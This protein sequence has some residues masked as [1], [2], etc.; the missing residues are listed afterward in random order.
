MDRHSIP[1]WIKEKFGEHGFHA[2]GS[3][4]RVGAG[5]ELHSVTA[6]VFHRGVQV[7]DVDCQMLDPDIARPRELLAL[8]GRVEFEELDVRSVGTAKKANA[9]DTAARWHAE[10][11]PRSVIPWRFT[12]IEQLAA[13]HIYEEG[14]GLLYVG[15]GDADVVYAA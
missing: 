3:W 9:L 14:G 10:P 11:I 6:Q 2:L 12:L 13:Q 1:H 15:H 4:Q 7:V 8:V 5:H